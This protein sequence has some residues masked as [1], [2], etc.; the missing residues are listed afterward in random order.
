MNRE[1]IKKYCLVSLAFNFNT[2]L[3]T[4]V[5]LIASSYG[6]FN[7]LEKD[8]TVL[9]DECCEIIMFA[10]VLFIGLHLIVYEIARN[11]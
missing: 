9:I 11:D 8:F 4:S 10:S 7:K 5:I 1:F 2:V 3:L 6:L